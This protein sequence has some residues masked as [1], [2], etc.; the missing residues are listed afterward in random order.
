MQA[1]TVY[2]KCRGK[3][4]TRDLHPIV[5]LFPPDLL[6]S[7]FLAQ[8]DLVYALHVKQYWSLSIGP[9]HKQHLYATFLVRI[10]YSP[11]L[12]PSSVDCAACNYVS[13]TII[14][15]HVASCQVRLVL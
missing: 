14:I 6:P 12:T 10:E 1:N 7:Y 3:Q 2:N 4:Q 15:S 5:A 8:L 9:F 13:N 11:T